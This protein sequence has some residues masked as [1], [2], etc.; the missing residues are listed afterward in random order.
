MLEADTKSDLQIAIEDIE[1]GA[2]VERETLYMYTAAVTIRSETRRTR[3]EK[4]FSVCYTHYGHI[5]P[6]CARLSRLILR[7]RFACEHMA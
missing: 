3:S 4:A 6:A 5:L 1:A 7:T 2:R